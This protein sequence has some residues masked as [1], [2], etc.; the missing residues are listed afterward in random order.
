MVERRVIAVLAGSS[1]NLALTAGGAVWRWGN[2][3]GGQLG[4]GD[5]QHQ[6]LPRKVEALTGQRVLAVSAG[7]GHSLAITAASSG[8]AQRYVRRSGV[9]ASAVLQLT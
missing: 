2:G 5:Q 1:H 9:P 7:F 4:H 3:G 6:L 8:G